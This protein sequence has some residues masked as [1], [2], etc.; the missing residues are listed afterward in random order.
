M[1]SDQ[2]EQ[3]LSLEPSD[4]IFEEEPLPAI[5]QLDIAALNDYSRRFRISVE[6]EGSRRR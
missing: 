3:S 6:E 1:Q 4:I 5:Q 2:D